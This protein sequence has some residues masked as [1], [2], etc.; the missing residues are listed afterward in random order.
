[1]I[2]VVVYGRNDAH[3]SNLAKR[4]VLSLNCL[5]EMLDAPGDEILF[6]DYNGADDLPT[7][8]EANADCLTPRARALLR[9]IR[10]RG[11]DH[12]AFQRQGALPVVE[13]VARNVALRRS[14]PANPWVLNTN[15]DVVLLAAQAGRSLSA[16]A[17]G[18]EPGLYHL[19]RF[20]IPEMLWES[21]DRVR[22][23]LFLADL[24]AHGRR[25]RLDQVVLGYPETIFD[26][27]G[28]FQLAP[29][30]ALFDIGGFDERLLLRGHC[31]PDLAVRLAQAGYPPRSLADRMSAWHCSH[32][33][34]FAGGGGG[35]ANN[36]GH[37]L[38][39]VHGD[40]WGLAGRRLEEIRLTAPPARPFAIEMPEAPPSEPLRWPPAPPQS[41]CCRPAE[42]A[43]YL[44]DLLWHLPRAARVALLGRNP[45]MAQAVTEMLGRLGFAHAPVATDDWWDVVLVD[46]SLDTDQ[47]AGR[48]TGAMAAELLPL[49]APLRRLLQAEQARVAAG[50]APRRLVFLNLNL[51]QFDVAAQAERVWLAEVVAARCDLVF[52]PLQSR[53]GYGFVRT[54][55]A[56]DTQAEQAAAG[57]RLLTGRVAADADAAIGIQEWKLPVLRLLERTDAPDRPGLDILRRRAARER[58]SAVLA[59]RLLCPLAPRRPG[60]VSAVAALAHWDDSDWFALWADHYGGAAPADLYRRSRHGWSGTQVLYA[61]RRLGLL[62]ED[63]TALVAT[64]GPCRLVAALGQHVGRVD[65][66]AAAEGS[67]GPSYDVAVLTEAL[68]KTVPARQLPPIL[69]ALS[70]RVVAGGALLVDMPVR[71]GRGADHWYAGLDL[72]ADAAGLA[73]ILADVGLELCGPLDLAMDADTLDC[74]G[75]HR[76]DYSLPQLC[77]DHYGIA[78]THAV[79]ALRKR[80]AASAQAWDQAAARLA[81]QLEA[82]P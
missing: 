3:W 53:L 10:V 19:P 38:A 66:L 49:E 64:P 30:Q 56:P 13:P 1:M 34:G 47:W 9:V 72:L 65:I 17:A 79:L 32:H 46:C 74:F 45:V 41:L 25:L 71:L 22:P 48:D 16:V 28:D 63:A 73:A 8:V 68:A 81:A 80:A 14:N 15:T 11:P 24:A 70:A 20:E 39:P 59:D 57:L 76:G 60:A 37:G 44:A 27:A 61:A 12:L 54:R 75:L 35:R 29:R 51:A 21:A 42:I 5:A 26:Y 33:R 6:T 82:R 23:D 2:S 78:C 7:F 55:P 31:D 40:D 67:G 58:P 43:P 77:R 50:A 62:R 18:L 4:A 52:A 36:S 69:A